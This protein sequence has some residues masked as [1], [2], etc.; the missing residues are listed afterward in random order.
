MAVAGELAP[1]VTPL[2]PVSIEWSAARGHLERHVSSYRIDDR[3]RAAISPGVQQRPSNP[4]MVRSPARS[5]P[6]AV[7]RALHRPEHSGAA[8]R[9]S[10]LKSTLGSC[11]PTPPVATTA[12]RAG[13]ARALYFGASSTCPPSASPPAPCSPQARRQ[14]TAVGPQRAADPQ[15]V[16]AYWVRTRASAHPHVVH[17]GWPVNLP[18]AVQLVLAATAHRRTPEH[19]ARCPPQR[20]D[21]SPRGIR[22]RPHAVTSAV[23][24]DILLRPTATEPDRHETAWRS[25]CPGAHRHTRTTPPNT[26]LPNPDIAGLPSPPRRSRSPPANSTLPPSVTC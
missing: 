3:Y 15:R 19:A 21:C 8:D 5:P 24:I 9:G 16:V 25:P 22:A 6:T 12:R 2:S 11:S 1:G 7:Q 17:P 14:P 18:T 13:L 20:P 23:T 26:N 10:R 4:A